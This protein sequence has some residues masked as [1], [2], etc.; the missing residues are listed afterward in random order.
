M[1][2]TKFKQH[3]NPC[4]VTPLSFILIII[5]LPSTTYVNTHHL[6]TS[7]HLTFKR[8][9]YIVPSL[10]DNHYIIHTS[11]FLMLSGNIELNLGPTYNLLC[12]YPPN[13]KLRSC[14]YF[15][16]KTIQLRPEYQQLSSSFALHLIPTHPHHQE[17]KKHILFWVDLLQDKI[18]I[19]HQSYYIDS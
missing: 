12:N 8:I 2:N 9:Y 7:L 16:S 13:L 3:E 4:L 5:F 19:H 10:K 15:T 6:L 11:L 1:Q 17:A 14:T 18:S